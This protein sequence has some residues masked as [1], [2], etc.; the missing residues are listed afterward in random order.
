M[1]RISI[2]VLTILWSLFSP[3]V[4]SQ[5]NARY[6]RCRKANYTNGPHMAPGIRPF[7]VLAHQDTFQV[8][9]TVNQPQAGIVHIELGQGSLLM[10]EDYIVGIS[11][12]TTSF[13][14]GS[15]PYGEYSLTISVD[16]DVLDEYVV[17]IGD[18]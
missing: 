15:Y 9:I 6:I 12:Q 3:Y 16:S 10:D 11:G 18:E 2:I 13:S 5:I 17:E 4:Y 1:K 8:S 7:T 14:M